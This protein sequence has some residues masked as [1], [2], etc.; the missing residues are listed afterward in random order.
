M[1]NLLE[2]NTWVEGIYEFALDD[3]VEGGPDGVD[4]LPHKQLAS[5]TQYLKSKVEEL[6]EDIDEIVANSGDLGTHKSNPVLD[7]PDYSVT[8]IK[9]A[10]GA[11]I[12]RVIG[13]RVI[14][15][16]T[17][18][19]ATADQPTGLWSKLGYMIKSITG[20][21]NWYVPPTVNL[22]DIATKY[23]QSTK[24]YAVG[25]IV[26]S[27]NLPSNSYAECT[28]AG[29]TAETEP[30][31]P[32]IGSTKV[33]G[34]VTWVVRDSR[35]ARKLQTARTLSLTGGVTGSVSFD[36]SANASM[37]ATVAVLG[38]I[39]GSQLTKLTANVLTGVLP[40]IDGSLV[41]G[42]VSS[43][44]GWT[45]FSDG[46][47]IQRGNV[48]VTSAVGVTLVFPIQFINTD[49]QILITDAGSTCYSWGSGGTITAAA[50]DVFLRNP[51]NGG[52]LITGV[53]RYFAIGRWK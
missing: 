43:G 16:T 12:D 2:T 37:A 28:V 35:D 41:T 31:W 11:A 44:T 14:D 7:H 19:T 40:A 8:S 46:T 42:I 29:T 45:K 32:A 6:R 5:R 51:A 30:T 36:G 1:A 24:T 27:P 13:N 18:A 15:D 47:L 53:G 33:D 9:I 3:W 52:A 39:D 34:T 48:S 4:N 22:N 49:Y 26:Y 17:V 50:I 25:N 23:W 20:Q 38:A 10:D 21:A